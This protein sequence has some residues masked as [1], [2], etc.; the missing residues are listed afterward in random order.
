MTIEAN[1]K[2][3]K[4]LKAPKLIIANRLDDGR[5]VFFSKGG[6]WSVTLNSVALATDHTELDALLKRA[7]I[8]AD[9]N[10]IVSPE[11]V[12]AVLSGGGEYNN[13]VPKHIKHVIQSQGPTV[14]R[15]LGYQASEHPMVGHA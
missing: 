5:V 11:P 14:R 3:P 12:D 1:K 13:A 15:D 6:G 2:L 4:P 10:V 8:S 9:A 7:Q